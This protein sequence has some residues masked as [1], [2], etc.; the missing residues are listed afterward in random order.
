MPENTS[1][2]PQMKPPHPLKSIAFQAGVSLATVDRVLHGRPGISRATRDRVLG[3]IGELDAQALHTRARGRTFTLDLVMEAPH[4]FSAA[5][6]RA[7]ETE[8]PAMRP[9]SFRCRFHL[10][11][12]M[13]ATDV[14]AIL[15]RIR[16]RGSD[17]V[18]LKAP[19]VAGV[20][21]MVDRVVEAGIPVVTLVTDLPGSRRIQHVGM[22]DRAA[23]ATAAYLATSV[24]G[25]RAGRILGLLSR[26]DFRGEA[27]R[28]AGF[29]AA[30]AAAQAKLTLHRLPATGGQ[31]RA[32][33]AL[34]AQALKGDPDILGVY[35][36]GGG[37]RAA[38]AAFD[39]A[40]RPCPI[41]IVH[42]LD[43]DNRA[44]LAEG[45]VDFA[46]HHDLRQ[47]AR[48]ACQVILRHHRLLPRDLDIRPS[49][50]AIATPYNLA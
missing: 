6:R 45:R 37:N 16:K 41:F 32:T 24:L 8:L 2:T 36:A 40:G 34:V 20:A 29:E 17:G 10:A 46:L 11:E 44:L 12:E 3:A 1:E 19:D 30:L 49:S 43:Q 25:G 26:S 39:L 9:A 33:G 18:I 27:D 22:D 4:R 14:E 5:V 35:S 7:F 31:D 23:G 50:I 38:R 28:C 13:Q 48:S 21:A 15:N 42:D 47:D